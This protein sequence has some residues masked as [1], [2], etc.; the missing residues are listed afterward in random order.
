MKKRR[1][2]SEQQIL[3]AIDRAHERLAKY[4]V[5]HD[6]TED[7]MKELIRNGEPTGP[8]RETLKTCTRNMDRIRNQ[9]LPHLGRKL[10]EMRTETFSFAGDKSIPV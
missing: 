9:V 2:K 1:Y 6:Y 7:V 8:Q 4:G 3:S 10:S 5:L